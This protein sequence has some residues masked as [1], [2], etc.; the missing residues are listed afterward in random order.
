MAG[1]GSGGTER[2]RYEK[3]QQDNGTEKDG[4]GRKGKKENEGGYS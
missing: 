3:K 2:E 4:E 1:I